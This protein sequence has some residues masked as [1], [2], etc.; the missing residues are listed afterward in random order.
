MQITQHE[1]D[2]TRKEVTKN[3]VIVS[4]V[5]AAAKYLGLDD[6]LNRQFHWRTWLAN[7][8]LLAANHI[9]RDLG[10]DAD[11]QINPRLRAMVMRDR[12]QDFDRNEADANGGLRHI[13]RGNLSPLIRLLD[14]IFA[15]AVKKHASAIDFIL[16]TGGERTEF[17]VEY[18]IDGTQQ[19]EQSVPTKLWQSMVELIHFH[20][21]PAANE[22]FSARGTFRLCF[23]DETIGCRVKFTPDSDPQNTAR[24][25]IELK[26]P[27]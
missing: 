24:V 10:T 13:N 26:Y 7:K 14:V 25:R 20:C 19:L 12:S 17:R 3:L 18:R 21:N 15:A 1:F 8:L 2:K 22:R 27:N 23:G 6:N 11:Q 4:H 5:L 9:L 16:S